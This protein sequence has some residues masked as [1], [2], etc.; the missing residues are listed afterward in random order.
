MRKLLVSMLLVFSAA[1]IAAAGGWAPIEEGSVTGDTNTTYTYTATQTDG[2][3]L[4]GVLVKLEGAT[5]CT[6]TMDFISDNTNTYNLVTEASTNMSSVVYMPEK[7][8]LMKRGAQLQVTLSSATN[9]VVYLL[10]KT[11]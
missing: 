4:Y 10:Q 6:L 1:L 2:I 9:F 11:E 7:D 8:I 3:A 5:D